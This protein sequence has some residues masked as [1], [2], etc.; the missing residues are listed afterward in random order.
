M[1]PGLR[2]RS[3]LV[4]PGFPS[5][6]EHCC[7]SETDEQTLPRRQKACEITDYSRTGGLFDMPRTK[8]RG[9]RFPGPSHKMRMEALLSGEVL[10]LLSIV[11][12][13]QRVVHIASTL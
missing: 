3:A 13:C 11:P 5:A 7:T 9:C 10:L 12:M 2:W 4:L 1:C 6:V 8:Q